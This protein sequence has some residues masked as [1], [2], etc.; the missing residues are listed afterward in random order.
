MM[1]RARSRNVAQQRDDAPEDLAVSA[2]TESMVAPSVN[3]SGEDGM[4]WSVR[5]YAADSPIANG[6]GA[7]LIFECDGVA[8]RV[9]TFP[10]HWREL[11]SF[12]LL[13]LSW[14]H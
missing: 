1:T 5:E 10:S 2:A 8:R 7:C 3:F 12:A 4:W 13:M 11:D 9:R 6:G 14:R